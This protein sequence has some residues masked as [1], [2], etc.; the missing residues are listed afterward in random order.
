MSFN[1]AINQIA[2]LLTQGGTPAAHSQDIAARLVNAL[3]QYYDFRDS[4]RN[5][6]AISNSSS[7]SSAF[8]EAFAPPESNPGGTAGADGADGQ[9]AYAWAA[10]KDGKDGTDGEGTTLNDYRSY[11]TFNFGG[12]GSGT[13]ID[14]GRVP[15]DALEKKLK[16]CGLSTGKDGKDAKLECPPGGQFP[17]G[18]ICSILKQQAIEIGKLRRELDTLKDKV[19]DIEKQLRDTVN[20]PAP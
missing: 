10:G 13:T 14:I 19:K 17:K 5:N 8:K 2:S 12:G 1:T 7:D 16:D 18:D 4:Q 9:G 3:E 15:C 6:S 20:C 11:E